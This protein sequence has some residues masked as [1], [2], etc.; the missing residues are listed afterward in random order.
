MCWMHVLPDTTSLFTAKEIFIGTPHPPSAQMTASWSSPGLL[1]GLA[2]HLGQAG[3]NNA[4]D[5]G[6]AGVRWDCHLA[7]QGPRELAQTTECS[8]SS[9]SAAGCASCSA[10]GSC[11]AVLAASWLGVPWRSHRAG[12]AFPPTQ[13]DERW[14]PAHARPASHFQGPLKSSLFLEF[15]I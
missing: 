9:L 3:H 7:Q 15:V 4:G 10:V 12:R 5:A 2:T 1:S 6:D 11:F 8:P 14:C 13:N